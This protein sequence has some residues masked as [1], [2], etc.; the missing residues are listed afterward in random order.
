MIKQTSR[1]KMAGK[2]ARVPLEIPLPL[3]QLNQVVAAAKRHWAGYARLKR[4]HTQTVALLARAAGCKPVRHPV[5]LA[6]VWH[7]PNRRLDPDNAVAGG[8]KVIADGLVAAGVLPDDSQTWTV[9]DGERSCR[10]SCSK[11]CAT[12]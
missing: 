4:R 3:M 6:F 9:F 7:L 1:P 10:S 2:A 8:V 12:F 5:T 11:A